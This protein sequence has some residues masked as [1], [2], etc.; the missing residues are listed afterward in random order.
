MRVVRY[1]EIAFSTGSQPNGV[2][3]KIRERKLKIFVNWQGA[4]KHK[5]VKMWGLKQALDG[6]ETN[7]FEIILQAYTL[8]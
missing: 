3:L 1:K 8:A 6:Y 7:A 4:L 5:G 2:K